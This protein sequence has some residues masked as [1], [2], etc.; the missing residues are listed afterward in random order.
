MRTF[1]FLSFYIYIYIYIYIICT[2]LHNC[3][4]L[5]DMVNSVFI[6]ELFYASA[7]RP[8]KKEPLLHLVTEKGGADLPLEIKGTLKRRH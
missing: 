8:E 3:N 7:S 4:K 5:T 6:S 2:S 1:F